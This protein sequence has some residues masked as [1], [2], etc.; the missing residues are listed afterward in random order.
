MKVDLCNLL[1]KCGLILADE[2]Y[3]DYCHELQQLQKNL[4]ELAARPNLIALN[5][6]LTLYNLK[7]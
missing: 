7:E 2:G 6:F 4:K 5:E 1:R 3:E